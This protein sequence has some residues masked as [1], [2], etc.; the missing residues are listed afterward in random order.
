[1]V[2]SD[3]PDDLLGA[4]V[5]VTPARVM[6]A[7]LAGP[8]AWAFTQGTGYAAMKPVC[9]SADTYLLWVISAIGLALAGAGASIAARRLSLVRTI[10]ID[11]GSRAVDVRYF[12]AVIAMALNVLIA[13]LIVTS[14]IP[15]LLLS[16]CE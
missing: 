16:P 4:E 5:V 6:A 13:L 9:A 8:A 12:V 2:D 7:V 15:L 10:A 3:L 11:E 1:V 14:M